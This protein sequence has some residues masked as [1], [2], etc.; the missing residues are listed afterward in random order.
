MFLLLGCNQPELCLHLL[1][2]AGPSKLRE[3]IAS[4]EQVLITH[5]LWSSEY[6]PGQ[7]YQGGVCS[8]MWIGGD[9]KCLQHLSRLS[10]M[11]FQR[12]G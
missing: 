7:N 10:S 3:L 12:R 2:F 5:Q 11:L 8:M 4:V 1:D 6:L 9:D